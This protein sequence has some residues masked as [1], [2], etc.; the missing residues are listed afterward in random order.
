[1]DG[2][3]LTVEYATETLAQYRVAVAADGSG[4]KEVDEARLYETEHASPQPF[5]PELEGLEWRPAQRL[6][7]YRPRRPR[8]D[9]A[10]ARLF[11][12]EEGD[13]ATG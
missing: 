1:M 8:E 9:R 5:L 6:A 10:Q 3:T 7:P 2:E 11:E 13:A 12:P 4:L